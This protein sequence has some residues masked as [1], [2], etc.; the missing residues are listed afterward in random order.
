M[1]AR[2][3]QLAGSKGSVQCCR[4]CVPPGLVGHTFP[5]QMPGEVALGDK[6]GQR[7]LLE[8]AHRAGVQA[9]F[10]PPCRQ[11]MLRQHHIGDTDAGS[12]T[13]GA[14][15]EVHHRA[16]CTRHALQAGQRPGIKT[17]LRIV[18][19]F[20]NIPPARPAGCPVQKLGPAACRH[21][22]A[23]GELVAGR[24]VAHRC[25]RPVQCFH[26]KAVLVHR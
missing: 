4:Q 21:G 25:I 2:K 16:V 19:I 20:Y 10:F 14:G 23:C 9:V 17:E 1:Q 15:G 13:A 18:I 5:G 3:G 6:A 8:P 12:Q 7:L 26:R 24:D 22:N 11:K